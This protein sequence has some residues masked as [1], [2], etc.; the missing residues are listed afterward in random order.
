VTALHVTSGIVGFR[1]DTVH[2][3]D[4]L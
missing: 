3:E 1:E 2:C 4:L